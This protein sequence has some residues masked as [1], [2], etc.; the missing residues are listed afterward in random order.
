MSHHRLTRWLLAGCISLCGAVALPA[1]A[2]K[3]PRPPLNAPGALD[4]GTLNL[5]QDQIR[6]I[7]LLRLDFQRMAIR[8]RSDIELRRIEID[9]LMITASADSNR[10]RS[11]VKERSALTAQLEMSTLENFL[12][13]KKLLT[14]DQ[15]DKLPGARLL[16]SP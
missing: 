2:V 16:A 15:L 7:N 14:N 6:R 3:I 5:S 11:L 4:W 1:V 13:I 12:S 8:L 9:K 10:L